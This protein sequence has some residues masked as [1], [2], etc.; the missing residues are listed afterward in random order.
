MSELRNQET[1]TIE[2]QLDP[3][4]KVSVPDLTKVVPTEP[5]GQVG[6]SLPRAIKTSVQNYMSAMKE[7][8]QQI[9]DLYDIFLQEV[10]GPLLAEV[11]SKTSYN[12]S[13]AARLL[14]LNRG[15]LR[16]KLKRYDLL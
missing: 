9:T 3:N 7:Q 16:K 12:Q 5:N 13:K 11:M 8:N 15:T 10:E 6:V 14:G 1:N 2:P 4:A